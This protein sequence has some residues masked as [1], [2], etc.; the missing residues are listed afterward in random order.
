MRKRRQK[1]RI[2]FN[3]GPSKARLAPILSKFSQIVHNDILGLPYNLEIQIWGELNV[4]ISFN[5]Q[6][7]ADKLRGSIQAAYS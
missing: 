1:L 5:N 6:V 2:D 7:L 3:M 4:H